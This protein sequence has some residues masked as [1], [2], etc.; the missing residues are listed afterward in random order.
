[1]LN[2]GRILDEKYEII[3]V[4]GRGG[5]GTVYLCKNNRLG[6]FWA[7]KEVNGQWKDKIDFLAEPNLLKNL[8]HIGIVRIIDIFY[9]DDNLYIVEDYI[10]GTTLKEYVEA[11]G[12][13]S[14]ELVT[15]ISLQLCS[16]LGYLHSFNPPI[17][18]RDLKPANIMIKSNNKVVLIDFGIARTYKENQ[19]GDTMIL[20]SMGYIAPEQLINAQSN[21]QTDIY[22]LAATMFFMLTGKSINLPS[23]L[24]FEKNYR[25][26]DAKSLVSV[27]KKASAIDPKSRYSDVSA[28][29]SA[30]NVNIAG[31]ENEKTMFMNSNE[32]ARDTTKTVLVEDKKP[33][34]RTKLIIIS[35]L[36]CII[37]L[38]VILAWLMNNKAVDK[39]DSEAKLSPKQTEAT[40]A[41]TTEETKPKVEPAVEV[42]EK[43]IVVMGMLDMKNPV[44]LSSGTSIGKGKDKVRGKDKDKEKE[45]DKDNNEDKNQLVQ[46]NLKPAASIA[47]SKLSIS[48][49][50]ILIIKDDVI[51]TLNFEN[52]AAATQ[53]LDISKTYLVNDKNEATKSYNQSSTTMMLIPQSSGKQEVKLYFKDLDIEQGSYILKTVLSSTV[54]K[55][56]NLSV[57]VKKS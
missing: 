26:D 25:S 30:L 3:K 9:E 27:I 50:S 22:S 47:N 19:E 2:P 18:Y 14:A 56:I 31:E 13:L 54:N 1:M 52:I 42:V 34:N 57:D 45:K 28:M 10:E 15:D 51:V 41:K 33:K 43:D 16:I 20:G 32:S 49:T 11:N 48:L 46:Y 12:S 4:L 40:V 24:M 36:A 23:E 29:Q 39:N 5:M 35:A 53:R 38:V 6:N 44:I 55:D 7:I 37:A 21:A 17:I 8:S